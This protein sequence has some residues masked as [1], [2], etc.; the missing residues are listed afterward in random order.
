GH[1]DRQFV[2]LTREEAANTANA[3]LLRVDDPGPRAVLLTHLGEQRLDLR[4]LKQH[5]RRH[6]LPLLSSRHAK[7][8]RRFPG[9]TGLGTCGC[10]LGA[11]GS[12]GPAGEASRR[13]RAG[14]PTARPPRLWRRCRSREPPRER[15]RAPGRR[16]PPPDAATPRGTVRAAG[17]G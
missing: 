2:V 3:D 6:R 1:L 12:A 13:S 11:A 16:R 4:T 9:T 14:C 8:N 17:R 10:P 15:R 5:P 7:R